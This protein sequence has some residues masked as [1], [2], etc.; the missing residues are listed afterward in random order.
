MD[1]TACL[2][3][4]YLIGHRLAL[5]SYYDY[6]INWLEIALKK[7]KE[8]KL[9]HPPIRQVDILDWLQYSYYHG[10]N[11][12]VALEITQKVR[13]LDPTFP[14]IGTN[15]EYYEK[16]LKE[17]PEMAVDAMRQQPRPP[18]LY[19]FGGSHYEALCR[20]EGV[21]VRFVFG[22][23]FF[24]IGPK[25]NSCFLPISHVHYEICRLIDWSILKS[26]LVGRSFWLID[27]LAYTVS[28][29]ATPLIEWLIDWLRLPL[30]HLL[31]AI[32]FAAVQED[33]AAFAM[34]LRDTRQP[35][36]VAATGKVWSGPRQSGHFHTAWCSVGRADWARQTSGTDILAA[37]HGGQG[38][39]IGDGIRQN[40][41]REIVRINLLPETFEM[42][43]KIVLN[44]E[45]YSLNSMK[46]HETPWN[47]MKLHRT[48]WN[49]I[50]LH[51]T[52]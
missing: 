31:C 1:C 51:K 4:G 16:L 2:F 24:S 52:P 41:H 5:E 9:E 42:R 12:L 17:L 13:E 25:E 50:E 20:G 3:P 7:W 19:D 28:L 40:S 21:P 38:G 22:D 32:C 15:M 44:L 18:V 8:E 33:F 37:R 35:L 45:I 30:L 11:A 10:G 6:A 49:S 23:D 27:W 43:R 36:L 14:T 26:L 34:L 46:L 48:P 29:I 47:S 39:H